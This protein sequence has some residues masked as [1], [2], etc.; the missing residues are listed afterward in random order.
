M[1]SNEKPLSL[2][3]VGSRDFPNLP[4]V[5]EYLDKIQSRQKVSKIVSGG[6]RGVDHEA[7]LWAKKNQILLVEHIPEWDK[8]HKRMVAYVRNK[9]IV[10][11]SDVI[12]AFYDGKS[13]GTMMSIQLA[14]E[15]KKKLLVFD[16]DGRVM[17]I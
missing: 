14:K 7:A 1:T 16:Q 2:G 4:L 3:V 6:A 12:V 11:Q 13:K 10:E 17:E 8:Y 9:L 5:S 15:M